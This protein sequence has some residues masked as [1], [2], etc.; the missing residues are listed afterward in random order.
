MDDRDIAELA[1]PYGKVNTIRVGRGPDGR[2]R[3]FAHIEFSSI[4]GSTAMFEASK[5]GPIYVGDRIARIDYAAGPRE[6]FASRDG[7][8][9]GGRDGRPPRLPARRR[10]DEY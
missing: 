6:G 10:N 3:G 9:D 7:N 5:A 4:D 8:R 2:A 1:E